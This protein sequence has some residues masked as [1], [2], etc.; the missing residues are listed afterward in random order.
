LVL[1]KIIQNETAYQS[2]TSPDKGAAADE[3]NDLF[4]HL[5]KS[6]TPLRTE[7]KNNF[8]QIPIS[9]KGSAKNEAVE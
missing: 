5:R 2:D 7:K 3:E 8:K 6:L 1:E 4:Q 9:L